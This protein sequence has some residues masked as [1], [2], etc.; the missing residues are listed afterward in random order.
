[1]R[2]KKL[3]TASATTFAKPFL[4]GLMWLFT[5]RNRRNGVEKITLSDVESILCV[6]LTRMGDVLSILPTLNILRR[7]L[8]NAFI[9]VAVDDQYVPLFRFFSSV[10][11]AIGIEHTSTY[12]GLAYA[13][14][15]LR[16]TRADLLC[17]MSPSYRNAFVSTAIRAKA[18][19]GYFTPYDSLTPFLTS[20]TIEGYGMTILPNVKY[21]RENIYSRS[22]KICE[23]LGIS[24]EIE[25]VELRITDSERNLFQRKLTERKIAI[26]KPYVVFHPFAG[27]EYRSWEAG[28]TVEFINRMN[29]IGK[30]VVLI[31]SESEMGKGESLV[32]RT[33]NS[34]SVSRAFGL[35][36][37]ELIVLLNDSELFVGTDS[38]PL[39]LA[40]I[41]NIP[42]VGLYG[43]AHPHY[44]APINPRSSYIFKQVECSP[45]DQRRCIRPHN[46]CMHLI[47]AEEVFEQSKSIMMN[48]L[49]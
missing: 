43:P 33:N 31:G 24:S 35:P 2:E 11:N 22:M 23:S 26:S 6:E 45:C 28:R 17:S 48:P 32:L 47:T 34:S 3:T 13:V 18:K 40:S 21:E 7:S 29:T 16:K 10:D 38:G 27:W 46:S 19:V 39:H 41:L 5:L 20:S 14:K 15:K 4:R 8:P 9:S 12:L 44:T 36:L 25:P 1:M 42:V 30:K 37:D 49:S